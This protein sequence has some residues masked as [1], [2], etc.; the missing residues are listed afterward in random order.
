MYM[1]AYIYVYLSNTKFVYYSI[2]GEKDMER[3]FKLPST[4]YI[5]G[6]DK[7]L[8]LRYFLNASKIK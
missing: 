5:G 2:T 7:A 1:Y 6:Q 3:V 8:P 4:T